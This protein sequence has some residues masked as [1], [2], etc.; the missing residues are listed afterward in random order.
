MEQN[1]THT[2]ETAKALR[3]Y[4]KGP[5]SISPHEIV[6]LIETIR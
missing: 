3:Q 4:F 6:Q 5:I 2:A 1:M